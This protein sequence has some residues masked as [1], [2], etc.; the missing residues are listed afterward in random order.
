MAI[1][2]PVAAWGFNKDLSEIAGQYKDYIGGLILASNDG[3][4]HPAE[5]AKV[6]VGAYQANNTLSTLLTNAFAVDRTN[7]LTVS[8]WV[9]AASVANAVDVLANFQFGAFY[10]RVQVQLSTTLGRRFGLRYA[11]A[12]GAAYETY[13]PADVN[14]H[15]VVLTLNAPV[16]VEPEGEDPYWS[17][18]AAL[19]VDGVEVLTGAIGGATFESTGLTVG[20]LSTETWLNG[21]IDALHIWQE[22]LTPEQVA[23]VY[24]SGRG[25]EYNNVIPTP[26]AAWG[27]N[28]DLDESAGQYKDYIGGLILSSNDGLDHPAAAA[29][30]GAG[31]YQGANALA[32]RLR[33]VAGCPGPTNA[34]GFGRAFSVSI[35][36]RAAALVNATDKIVQLYPDN[37]PTLPAMELE[38]SRTVT[39]QR[40]TWYVDYQ[41]ISPQDTNWHNSVIVYSAPYQPDP[42]GAPDYWVQ[43]WNSYL[44]GSV[45]S[46]IGT[47]EWSALGLPIMETCGLDVCG[48]SQYFN[49]D[50]D[51]LHIWQEALTAEQ[52]AEVYNAGTGWEYTPPDT[53]PDAFDFTDV[54]DADLSTVYVSDSQVVTGMDACTAISI[55]GGEYRI[56]GGAWTAAAGTI[57]PGDTLELRL[58]SSADPETATTATVTVGTLAVDWSVT[59]GAVLSVVTNIIGGSPTT[60]R[61]F[62]SRIVQGMI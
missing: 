21:D 42:E 30:V 18:S 25:W 27:F 49:G 43:D 51:A 8:M 60:S 2:T 46:V 50:V 56:N 14:W 20:G 32:R 28:K 34:A 29:K 11:D 12:I 9:R 3:L 17:T 37:D 38:Y 5:A 52:V 31:A 39:Y 59:T 48:T 7:G 62:R 16:F 55:T 6:G 36:W 58:T 45:V 35:W 61:I 47:T 19:L 22:A 4:D 10:V 23:E 1:P 33:C 40:V 44:D 54:T 53:T 15:H 57:D 41:A 26:V 24:N 13:V